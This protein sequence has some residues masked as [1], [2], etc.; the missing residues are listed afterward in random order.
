MTAAQLLKPCLASGEGVHTWVFYAA[1]RLIEAGF[2]D[3]DAD[4]EIEALMTREP[5]PPSEIMDALRSARGERSRSA[6]RWSPV[7]PAAIAEIAKSGPTLVELISR[8]PEQIQFVPQ[9]RAELF[10]D[11]LFPGDPWLCVGKA[12]NQFFT[13]KREAWRGQLSQQSL[14]V[15]SPMSSQKG[16]T[17]RGKSSCHSEANTGPRR[18]LV[19]EFDSGT[20]NQQAALLW[21]FAK[22]APLAL[23]V[24]SGSK[25]AH[26]W[27]F[28]DGEPEDKLQRFFDYAVS[29]GADHKTWSRCQFV[30]MPDGRRADGKIS[31]ALNLAGIARVP[32]NGRQA[33]LYFNPEVIR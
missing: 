21:H 12:S 23:V 7:N 13:A 17:K 20:L 3:R 26:S 4:A 11:A 9:S 1:C 31:N 27:Y 25:S 19:V 32:P 30:R 22:F 6:P 33:V 10:V 18:F 5:S 24:F 2:S 8:S 15:P 29:L 16:R 14:I 28:C